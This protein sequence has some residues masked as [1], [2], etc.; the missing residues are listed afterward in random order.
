MK[1]DDDASLRTALIEA[2]ARLLA[3]SSDNDISTRAVCEAVGI[4]QPRLY[5]LFGDKRGLLDAVADAAFERYAQHKAQLEKTD[6]PVADLWAGWDDHSAFAVANPAAYQLMFAPQ[7]GSQSKARGRILALLEATLLR[8][9]AA[10]ALRVDVKQ[11]AQLVLSIHT[12]VE[13]S[14]IAQPDLFDEDLS[15][16]AREAAFG[17]ILRQSPVPDSP[18]AAVTDSARQL[19]SQLE[20]TGSGALEPAEEALLDRWLERIV[21]P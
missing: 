11:A 10:G 1:T 19:R 12:G 17:A 16:R 15:Q 18:S 8:C 21:S 9:S 4:T 2:A 13:L 3:E 5:R 7:P 6:D 20:L 14:R